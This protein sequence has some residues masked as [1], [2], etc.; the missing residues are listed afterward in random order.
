[1]KAFGCILDTYEKLKKTAFQIS[2]DT[3]IYQATTKTAKL[4]S[5]LID[6]SVLTDK[7][8]CS[9]RDIVVFVDDGV[10]YII[11]FFSTLSKLLS[12]AGFRYSKMYVPFADSTEYPANEAE[13]K[14]WKKIKGE[15]RSYT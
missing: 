15:S 6:F 13:L 8:F 2:P 7:T 11:P 12:Y 10:L 3:K 5:E 4:A 1:M 9:K 14:K